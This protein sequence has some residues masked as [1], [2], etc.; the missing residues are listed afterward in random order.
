M[1]MELEQVFVID[2]SPEEALGTAHQKMD[3]ARATG[4]ER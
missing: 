3:A 1:A 4:D 2:E